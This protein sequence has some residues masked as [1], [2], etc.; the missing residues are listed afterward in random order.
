MSK[1]DRDY[2]SGIRK[3]K[4]ILPKLKAFFNDETVIKIEDKY[5]VFDFEG[6]KKLIELKTRNCH[7]D[8]YETS[9]VG[10]N[11]IQYA[12]TKTDIDI[13]FFI[14]FFDGIFYYKYDREEK[15]LIFKEGGRKDRGRDEI[16]EY[17][18]IPLE[19]LKKL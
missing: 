16:K 19:Y 1:K 14:W 11:K 17:C 18:Y 12:R 13:Y 6:D 3:E 10:F 8:Y 5:A 2:I 9:M 15:G 4:L 7:S